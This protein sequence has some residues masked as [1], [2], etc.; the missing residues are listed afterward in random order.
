MSVLIFVRE[1]YASAVGNLWLSFKIRMILF[2][3]WLSALLVLLVLQLCRLFERQAVTQVD[4][5]TL[6]V[7]FG[8]FHIFPFSLGLFGFTCAKC[9]G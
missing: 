1:F 5:Y 9:N 3:F 6:G 4:M 2:E 7:F 8:S